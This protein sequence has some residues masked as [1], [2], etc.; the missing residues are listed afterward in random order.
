[1]QINKVY[2]IESISRNVDV[3]FLTLWQDVPCNTLFRQHYFSRNTLVDFMINYHKKQLKFLP[4]PYWK[5]S[6]VSE[7]TSERNKE[8]KKRLKIK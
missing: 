1:M 5:K 6:E 8:N 7:E 3:Y 2:S 4:F